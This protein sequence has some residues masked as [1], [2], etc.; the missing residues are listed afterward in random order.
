[1]KLEGNSRRVHGRTKEKAQG[2]IITLVLYGEEKIEAERV[3]VEKCLLCRGREGKESQGGR[4]IKSRDE[5]EK[6]E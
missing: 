5:V 2:K 6:K 1:M 4:E 3:V